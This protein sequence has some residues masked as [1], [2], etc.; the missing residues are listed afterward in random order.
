[1]ASATCCICHEALNGNVSCVECGHVYHTDCVRDW[2]IQQQQ[3]GTARCPLC[4]NHIR[5]L[6][7]LF[8]EF[9]A[10][11]GACC[12]HYRQEK[13]NLSSQFN[14]LQN[15][16]TGLGNELISVSDKQSS[17]SFAVDFLDFC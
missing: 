9:V 5:Y 7:Q 4:R 3:D 6:K 1:M 11:E 12:Q 16:A 8:V 2:L 14:D 10:V 15:K 17:L 13:D